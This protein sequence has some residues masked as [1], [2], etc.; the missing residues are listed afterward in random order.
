M[1]AVVFGGDGVS[2]LVVLVGG[3]HVSCHQST[4]SPSQEGPAI[5][6]RLDGETLQGDGDRREG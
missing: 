1:V 3:G 5:H 2:C 4:V 6:Q